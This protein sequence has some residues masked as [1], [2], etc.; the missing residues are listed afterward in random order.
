MRRVL[1][2]C[3]LLVLAIG[4]PVAFAAERCGCC[5]VKSA[6]AETVV[7]RL[8]CPDGNAARCSPAKREASGRVAIAPVLRTVDAILDSSGDA[9]L[10][11][12]PSTRR[13]DAMP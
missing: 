12:R 8:C 6:P 5:T 3:A 13:L 11:V 10:P 9:L 4:L 7:K 1:A 2:C